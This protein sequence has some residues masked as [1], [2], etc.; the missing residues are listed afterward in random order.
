MFAASLTLLL[1]AL[2]AASS[3]N[4]PTAPGPLSSWLQKTYG[5]AAR[6]TTPWRDTQRG[7]DGNLQTSTRSVC[8]AQDSGGIHFIAVCSRIHDVSHVEPGRVDLFVVTDGRA[9]WTVTAKRRELGSGSFGIPGPV[10]L[11]H[12][13]PG[14]L[15]FQLESPYAMSGWS[16][17]RT[18]L[19]LPVATS[20]TLEPALDVATRLDNTGSYEAGPTLDM[21]C[22]LRV[23]DLTPAGQGPAL[24]LHAKGKRGERAID[25]RFTLPFDGRAWTPPSNGDQSAQGC[26]E[27]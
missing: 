20:G 11:L 8:A 7:A 10:R 25:R 18:T 5:G 17:Q 6:A 21:T 24:V 27:D 1:G 4:T 2:S 13:A 22:T 19:Y 26:A 12:L 16:R 3:A 23:A 14:R 15:A 9:G